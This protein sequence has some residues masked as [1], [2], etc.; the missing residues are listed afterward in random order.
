MYYEREFRN[1][2]KNQCR[3][4]MNF[5][6]FNKNAAKNEGIDMKQW[7]DELLSMVEK[8]DKEISALKKKHKYLYSLDDKFFTVGIFNSD[9]L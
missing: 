8:H 6:F 4:E 9:N 7:A 5:L 1:K 2:L 3:E